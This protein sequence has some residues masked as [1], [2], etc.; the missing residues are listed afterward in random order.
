MIINIC[1]G[2]GKVY[3]ISSYY[4]KEILKIREAKDKKGLIELASSFR[5]D[6]EMA[7]KFKPTYRI[8]KT[9]LTT[10]SEILA[11]EFSP[12]I[13]VYAVCPGW[14]KTLI[15]G[16]TATGTVEEGVDTTMWLI[17]EDGAKPTGFWNNRS[18]PQDFF[19]VNPLS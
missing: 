17:T 18:Q 6:D 4:Q 10:L 8:S 1:S 11:D 2:M 3:E 5:E 9:C 14:C 13:P 12:S 19:L 7:K 15:G 16:P